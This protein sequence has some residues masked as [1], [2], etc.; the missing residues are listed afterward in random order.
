MAIIVP[1]LVCAFLTGI[2]FSVGSFSFANLGLEAIVAGLIGLALGAAVYFDD[3]S[4]QEKYAL[5]RAAPVTAN[6]AARPAEW[7]AWVMLAIPLLAGALFWSPSYFQLSKS[8][9]G[10][11]GLA[12]IVGTALLGYIDLRQLNLH[13]TTTDNHPAASPVG[14]FVAMQAIWIVGFPIHFVARRRYGGRN[15]IIPALLATAVFVG[16]TVRSW[17]V[18]PVLPAVNAPEVLSLVAQVVEDN[19]AG[20]TDAI[21]K[22]TVHDAVELSFD[23]EK[24]RRVA[25]A[26]LTTNLGEG[27][28][29]FTVQWQDRA[30]GI[31]AVQVYSK[32]P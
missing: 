29:F 19:F 14:A 31:F 18:G 21:G 23:A 22:A 30:K 15:L 28:I 27:P 12:V 7:L 24:Q 3:R 26:R 6:E 20:G 16:P 8:A 13:F 9:A 32:E 10:I 2:A 4:L 5:R 11:L 1:G 25:R 17:L